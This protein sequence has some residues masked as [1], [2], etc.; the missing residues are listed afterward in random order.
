MWWFHIFFFNVIFMF[1]PNLGKWFKFIHV[2]SNGLNQKQPATSDDNCHFL[3]AT[4][5]KTHATRVVLWWLC[6]RFQHHSRLHSSGWW[7]YMDLWLINL[8]LVLSSTV[9]HKKHCHG[10][11]IALIHRRR[12][13]FD[14]P[15]SGQVGLV[16]TLNT[17]LQ[18][19]NNLVQAQISC[20]FLP[21]VPKK[22]GFQIFGI[23]L[24]IRLKWWVWKKNMM[25]KLTS[26]VV[27]PTNSQGV[28]AQLPKLDQIWMMWFVWLVVS[29]I[30]YVHPYLGKI[31][32]LTN[33][34]QM[35]W[36]YQ[37]DSQR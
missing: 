17:I 25:W 35:G 7:I 32:I 26:C 24:E 10:P 15:C 2:F 20:W 22:F 37:L 4:R 11:C 16:V 6:W 3:E 1:T 36:N 23:F 19:I 14:S 28:G 8:V 29:N 18:S 21:H 13:P 31:P 9:L 27:N 12:F 34:F 30:L 33:I 5:K